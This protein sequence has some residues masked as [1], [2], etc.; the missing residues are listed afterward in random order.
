MH[1]GPIVRSKIDEETWNKIQK[2]GD[3][4]NILFWTP[5]QFD[6]MQL[7][8]NKSPAI[9]HLLFTSSYSTGKTEVMKG[10]IRK[11]LENKQLVHFIFCVGGRVDKMPILCPVKITKT[12]S[13]SVW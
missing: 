8:E 5:S 11:L 4:C 13:S 3:Y 7:D 12:T 6:L 2:Q 10:M 9:K 1:A